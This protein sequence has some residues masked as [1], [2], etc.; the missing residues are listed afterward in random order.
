MLISE[1]ARQK[2]E[3]FTKEWIDAWNAHDP[4]RIV[5]HYGEPLRYVSPLVDKRFPELGGVIRDKNTLK[6][7]VRMGLE[8]RPDLAF[9]LI[10]VLHSVDGFVMFYENA[11]ATHSAEYI[12]LDDDGRARVS[13]ACYSLEPLKLS[14][15]R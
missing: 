14:S 3:A 6:Q 9:T 8:Q 15:A 1:N 4:E 13:I 11:F 5:G 12:E 2:A 10:G 7:Y